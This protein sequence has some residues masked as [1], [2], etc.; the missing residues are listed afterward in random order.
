M[1]LASDVDAVL[2]TYR[3]APTLLRPVKRVRAAD[4]DNDEDITSYADVL[5]DEYW[6]QSSKSDSVQLREVI[7]EVPYSL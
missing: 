2:Q 7:H 5:Q 6:N 3:L 4:G 1:L